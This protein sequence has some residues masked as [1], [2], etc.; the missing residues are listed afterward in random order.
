MGNNH[1]GWATDTAEVSAWLIRVNAAAQELLFDLVTSD[2]DQGLIRLGEFAA[3]IELPPPERRCAATLGTILV[4]ICH[5]CV[6][7]FHGNNS[8]SGCNCRT[9]AW[10]HLAELTRWYEVDPRVAFDSW[11][12]EFAET[13]RHQHPPTTSSQI[14][15]EFRADPSQDWNWDAVAHRFGVNPRSL[16]ERFHQQ[17]GLNPSDYL[18]L[19]RATR[20]VTIIGETSTKVEAVA[21]AVGYCTKKPLYEALRRWAGTTPKTIRALDSDERRALQTRLRIKCMGN[22]LTSPRKT[23][24][25]ITRGR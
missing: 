2:V 18:Q 15:S 11:V 17:F 14:A 8:Q 4:A 1:V 6:E 23:T 22:K 12:R 24:A 13:F 7:T 9:A 10:S 16:R 21:Y 3:R 25:A 19:L 20:A 5:R